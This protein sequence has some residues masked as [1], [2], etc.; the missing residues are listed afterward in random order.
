MLNIEQLAPKFQEAGFR[1]SSE[2]VKR[3]PHDAKLIQADLDGRDISFVVEMKAP[4]GREDLRT[5]VEQLKHYEHFAGPNTIL[6]VAS[7]FLRPNQ[8]ELLKEMGVGY[9]DLAGNAYL[10]APGI[11]IDREE[12]ENPFGD[13]REDIDVYADKA[14]IVLR[15]L[16]SEPKRAWKIREIAGVAR[17]NPGWVSRVVRRLAKAGLVDFYRGAGVSLLRGED[18]LKEWTDAYDW[19]KNKF[20]YY[21]CDA[22]DL[23]DVLD[24]ISE[25][26]LESDKSAALGF[27]AGA[28][29]VAPYTTFNEVHLILDGRS[30]DSIRPDVEQQLR[31][32]PKRQSANLIL[33]RPHYKNSVLFGARKI[34]K[35]YVVSD[36]QLYLDLSRYPSQGQEQAEHLL[37]RI[38]QPKFDSSRTSKK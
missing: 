16:F 4:S 27:H 9:L 5:A 24:K 21:Y 7:Q 20:Y 35:W 33:V 3:L 11:L 19:R 38:L 13:E 8:R 1:L 30:F 34:E 18:I 6:V 2:D 14:S 17:V 32:E 10:R 36:V 23:Q 37:Q 31:L 22:S 12:K 15:V 29:L 25:L 28:S 26:K